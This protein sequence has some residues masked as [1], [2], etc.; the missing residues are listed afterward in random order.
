MDSLPE[1]SGHVSMSPQEKQC[2]SSINTLPLTFL[3]TAMLIFYPRD[4]LTQNICCPLFNFPISHFLVDFAEIRETNRV[5]A[6]W[7]LVVSP[8]M[9]YAYDGLY[10]ALQ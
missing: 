9:I 7:R 2:S 5:T 6:A 1:V 3:F 10:A 4:C 8:L